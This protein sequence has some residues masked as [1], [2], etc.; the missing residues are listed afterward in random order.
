MLTSILVHGYTRSGS[1]INLLI[2]VIPVS[3]VSYMQASTFPA[4]LD[5][6]E[7]L[8]ANGWLLTS[9][10]AIPKTDTKT[11]IVFWIWGSTIGLQDAG[12]TRAPMP[13]RIL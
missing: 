11:K 9:W 3:A 2:P 12:E 1:K 7:M 4:P 5:D 8:W 10:R 13:A 6:L